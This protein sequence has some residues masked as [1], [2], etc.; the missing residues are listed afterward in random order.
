M[1]SEKE[2]VAE[3]VEACDEQNNPTYALWPLGDCGCLLPQAYIF[4][5]SMRDE[6]DR[7]QFLQDTVQEDFPSLQSQE[8]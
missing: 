7:E 2:R 3:L 5:E 8:P 1:T 4:I 6:K